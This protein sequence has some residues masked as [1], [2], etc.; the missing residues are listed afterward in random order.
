MSKS[1]TPAMT[2]IG[3]GTSIIGDIKSEHDLRIEGYLKGT[4]EVGGMLV[5]SPSGRIE[6]QV[7]ART[8]TV[9]GQIVGNLKGQDKIVLESTSSL[10]GDL[11]T[12]ELVIN[13]GAVFQGNCAMHRDDKK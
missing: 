10:V 11:Q 12:R 1:I 3:E 6:G 13:E 4:V 2:F 8:A 7:Q 5:L 9:A